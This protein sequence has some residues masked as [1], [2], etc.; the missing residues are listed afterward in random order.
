MVYVS[1]YRY[2]RRTRALEIFFVCLRRILCLLPLFLLPPWSTATLIT[3]FV[4]QHHNRVFVDVLVDV[5]HYSQLHQRHDYLETW[6]LLPVRRSLRRL[7]GRGNSYCS[8][9]QFFHYILFYYWGRLRLAVF[10]RLSLLL[11]R[12]L[13]NLLLVFLAAAVQLGEFISL[14]IL[15]L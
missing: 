6:I 10:L 12:A 14:F 4:G 2:Y 7:S 11:E 5:G 3:Q 1:H 9:R 15:V 13:L 8:C